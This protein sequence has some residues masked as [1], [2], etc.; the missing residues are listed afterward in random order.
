MRATEYM[1][2]ARNSRRKPPS[3]AKVRL[4]TS[5]RITHSLR[6]PTRKTHN[7]GL[8]CH[9]RTRQSGSSGDGFL[10]PSP[11]RRVSQGGHR[12]VSQV[13]PLL[14]GHPLPAIE[15][16]IYAYPKG[17]VWSPGPPPLICLTRTWTAASGSLS[18]RVGRRSSPARFGVRSP[19]FENAELGHRVDKPTYE[20]EA[21]GSARPCSRRSGNWP[22][23][24][25]RSS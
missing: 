13:A 21:P 4:S 10:F 2:N 6:F 20:R 22:R 3:A 12:L 5:R 18:L 15:G 11:Y 23:P 17:R 9:P 8:S 14:L 16:I 7:F 24:T 1:Q 19:M 25:S